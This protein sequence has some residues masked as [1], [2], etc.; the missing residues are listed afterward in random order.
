MATNYSENS[1]GSRRREVMLLQPNHISQL[2]ASN[3]GAWP[4]G[5]PRFQLID[6]S[7]ML[8]GWRGRHAGAL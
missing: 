8:T 4:P 1:C 2:P 6:I 5:Q 3:A 7:L